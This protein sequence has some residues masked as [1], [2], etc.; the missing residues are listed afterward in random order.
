MA[1]EHAFVDH[2]PPREGRKYFTVAEANRALT[3]VRRI[4]ADIASVYRQAMQL[5]QGIEEPAPGRNLDELRKQYDDAMDRLNGCIDELRQ[6]GVELKD[7]E[8][9]LLDFPAVHQGREVLLCWYAGEEQVRAWHEVDAGFAGRQDVAL[10][11]E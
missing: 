10:L 3:Y 8:K 1:L 5:R 11:D 6:V 7:F 2:H 4:V 9:G